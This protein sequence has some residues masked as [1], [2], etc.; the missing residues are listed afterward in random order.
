MELEQ[1]GAS[2]TPV[3]KLDDNHALVA[4][5]SDDNAQVRDALRQE[6]FPDG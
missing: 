3:W 2:Y 5:S 6:L 1:A 4:Q